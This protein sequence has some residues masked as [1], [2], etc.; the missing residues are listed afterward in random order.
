MVESFP[1]L[2]KT[3]NTWIRK[4]QWIPATRNMKNTT[5]RH[6]IIKLPKISD[7]EKTSEAAGVKEGRTL[8]IQRNK[9]KND[10]QHLVRN[11]ACRIQHSDIWKFKTCQSRIIYP[12]RKHVNKGLFHIYKSW[13]LYL[14]TSRTSLKQWWTK[15]SEQKAN[16]NKNQIVHKGMMRV[17]NG[18]CWVSVQEIF[19]YF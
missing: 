8:Y 18:E 6:F 4:A 9:H 5:P 13:N 3:I 16:H 12:A 15:S 2:V 7:K 14:S 1:N 17:R 10:S 11:T 19:S